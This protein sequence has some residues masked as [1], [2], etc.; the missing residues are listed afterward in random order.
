M[1]S[2][3]ARHYYARQLE[4]LREALIKPLKFAEKLE[5]Q[6]PALK[7]AIDLEGLAASLKRYPDTKLVFQ[8]T[9][10]VLRATPCTPWLTPFVGI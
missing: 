7:G 10:K 2:K 8:Q 4:K 5:I 1:K 9:S 6:N 3:L